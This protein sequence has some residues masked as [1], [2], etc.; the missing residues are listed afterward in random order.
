MLD[1]KAEQC[2]FYLF[3]VIVCCWVPSPGLCCVCRIYPIQMLQTKHRY[4]SNLCQRDIGVVHG[5][6]GI[7]MGNQRT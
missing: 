2:I 1:R 7:N 3:S 6:S 5:P 4:Y